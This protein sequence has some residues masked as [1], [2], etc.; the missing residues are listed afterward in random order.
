MGREVVKGIIASDDYNLVGAV[1]I[2]AIGEDAGTLA[3][4][5]FCGV[6]VEKDLLSLLRREAVDAAIDFTNP[7]VVMSDIRTCL[8]QKVPVVVGTTGITGDDVEDVRKMSESSGTNCIIAPNFTIGAVLMM[9]FSKMA[10]K[11]FPNAEIIELHHN[12]K[13]DAP[14][15]TAI[16]TAEMIL[17]SRETR[18][19]PP[20]G[21]FEK[22]AGARGGELDGIRLHAVRLPGF[23]AH[24][25]VIFGDSGQVLTIRHDSMSRECYIPGVLMAVKKLG[26]INGVVYGLENLL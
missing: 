12:N 17:S 16:K 7:K 8:E 5:G 24:Q 9:I 23:I 26:E 11:Y 15:G 10:A 2:T 18:P 1:D 20:P 22:L 19:S 4:A 6:K 3:G 25:E 13:M 21:E 14:S